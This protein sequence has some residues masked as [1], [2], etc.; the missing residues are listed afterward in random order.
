MAPENPPD[1]PKL[2]P[3][4][5]SAEQV[6]PPLPDD[7]VEPMEGDAEV[8]PSTAAARAAARRRAP[9]EPAAE[10]SPARRPAPEAPPPDD[11]SP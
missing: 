6:L 8:E 4:R 11:R 3:I 5:E 10:K 2:P 9:R 7:A 1:L